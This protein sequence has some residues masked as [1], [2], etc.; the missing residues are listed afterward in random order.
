MLG[1]NVFY[2]VNKAAKYFDE[3]IVSYC[4]TASDLEMTETTLEMV[5]Q[6]VNRSID[7]LNKHVGWPGRSARRQSRACSSISIAPRDDVR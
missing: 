3:L 1:L 6:D 5:S 2:Q 7:L 4:N